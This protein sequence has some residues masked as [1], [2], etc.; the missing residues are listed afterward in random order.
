MIAIYLCKQEAPDADPK[1]ILIQINL[2]G[3]QFFNSI[4][5]KYQNIIK[6]LKNVQENNTEK[7][8]NENDKEIPKER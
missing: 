4:I 3:S 2:M 7:V 5:M 8:T 6:V 1:A